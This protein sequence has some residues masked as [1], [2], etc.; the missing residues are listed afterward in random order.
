MEVIT[1]AKSSGARCAGFKVSQSP[2]KGNCL[3]RSSTKEE[4]ELFVPRSICITRSELLKYA[5]R[6]P[7]F[8]AFLNHCTPWTGLFISDVTQNTKVEDQTKKLF[9][10]LLAYDRS[11]HRTPWRTYIDSLPPPETLNLPFL[12]NFEEQELSRCCLFAYDVTHLVS[13][14]RSE[15]EFVKELDMDQEESIIGNVSEE[16]WFGWRAW[17]SSRTLTDED[18]EPVLVPVLDL[19]NHS[20]FLPDSS[21]PSFPL[22]PHPSFSSPPNNSS[23]N[24]ESPSGH[25]K[26]QKEHKKPPVQN[27]A[28]TPTESGFD[29][30]LDPL[31]P[32]YKG[33]EILFSYGKRGAAELLS[34]YGFV[35]IRPEGS[36]RI[37]FP[38]PS[39][40]PDFSSPNLLQSRDGNEEERRGS[41]VKTVMVMPEDAGTINSESD[42]IWFLTTNK[43][44]RIRLG[45]TRLTRLDG[46]LGDGHE[47]RTCQDGEQ[48]RLILEA[49]EMWPLFELRGIT[50]LI[51]IL[52]RA[53]LRLLRYKKEE[54]DKDDGKDKGDGSRHGS[55]GGSDECGVRVRTEVRALIED[56]IAQ[57]SMTIETCLEDL[58]KKQL[59]LSR[60]PIVVAYLA[61]HS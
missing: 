54:H 23:P 38:I 18:K 26:H 55:H 57:E 8:K 43:E 50:I 51:E 29:I 30:V 49:D 3:V 48:E 13:F 47:V 32:P 53:R 36:R 41:G 17:I 20:S 7:D 42:D 35:E 2:T 60:E 15:L 6:T 31:H 16:Q 14:F 46:Q 28:W 5:V 44:E 27:C 21:P 58:E 34:N 40:P 39:H 11:G 9:L 61:Q 1:W 4:F 56:V 37:I 25:S 52:G 12:W 22:P 59:Q 45:M 24:A 33:D 10:L 19:I